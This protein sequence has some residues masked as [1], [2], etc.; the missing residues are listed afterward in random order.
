[1]GSS[2]SAHISIHL[3]RA[4]PFFYAGER[5]SGTV[6]VHL[7]EG[8]IKIDEIFML[9]LGETGYTTAITVVTGGNGSSH[10]QTNYHKNTFLKEKALLGSPG[11]EQK[12]LIY[13]TGQYSWRFDMLLPNQLPPT[14][15]EHKKYPHVRYYLKFVID[16]PWYKP[17]AN[18]TLALI[19]YPC[20]NPLMNSQSM[21][22]NQFDNHNRKDV[23]LRGNLDKLGYV[24]GDMIT[25]TIEIDNPKRVLL[26]GIHVSLVQ[27][28]KI[29]CNT[30]KEKIIDTTL[31]AI[32]HT[33]A[34]NVIE[35]IAFSIPH[36]YLA[37]TYHFHGGYNDKAYAEV[38]Y[39]LEFTVKAEGMFTNFDATVPIMIGTESDTKASSNELYHPSDSFANS[40]SYYPETNTVEEQPPPTYSSY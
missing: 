13:Q 26:K 39:T 5:V 12:E 16:K 40:L 4:N 1:M 7:K 22:S 3:D 18:E 11:P 15:N 35:K 29:E 31:S 36:G 34:E 9:L 6:N 23:T 10:T 27:H 2:N 20:V 24:S 37:P 38:F 21:A 28:N 17:N 33:K 8:N 30:R 32:T 19:V 14:V 25:G